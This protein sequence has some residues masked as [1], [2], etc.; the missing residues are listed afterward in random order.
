MSLPA[1]EALE[2]RFTL[3]GPQVAGKGT[4][5]ERVHELNYRFTH[6]LDAEGKETECSVCHRFE[7][8]CSDCHAS[9]GDAFGKPAWH[10]GADWGA[11]SVAVGAGGELRPVPIRLRRLLGRAGR[12][13][14]RGSKRDRGR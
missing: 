14:R 4:L 11:V 6:P 9:E 1:L 2:Q 8:F 5:P 10:G 13:T 12:G 7:S 3:N